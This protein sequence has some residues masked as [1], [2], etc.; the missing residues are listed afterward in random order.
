PQEA[1][2]ALPAQEAPHTTYVPHADPDPRYPTPAEVVGSTAAGLPKRR[3]REVDPLA[4]AAI[5][6]YVPSASGPTAPA[7]PPGRSVEETASRMGAFARGTRKGRA[8]VASDA[9]GT[10]TAGETGPRTGAPDAH[11]AS[12]SHGDEQDKGT[13]QP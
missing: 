13:A 9:D 5:G 10:H 1:Q 7:D 4:A 3:R 2:P 8:E 12:T 11:S 6:Q